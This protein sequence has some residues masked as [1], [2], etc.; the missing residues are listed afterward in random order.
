MTR[1]FIFLFLANTLSM[2]SQWEPSYNGLPNSRVSCMAYN[3]NYLFA[4]F[5]N[6]GVYLS[7]DNGNSW[8][9]RNY[10]LTDTTVL[11]LAFQG[12]NLFAVTSM[13]RIYFSSDDGASWEQRLF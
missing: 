6:N 2:F 12:N 7:T 5:Y 9:R 11:C 4:G 8:S 10:G 3:G 1:L 13:Y